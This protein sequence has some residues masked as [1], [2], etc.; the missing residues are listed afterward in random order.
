MRSARNAFAFALAFSICAPAWAQ[1]AL[2]GQPPAAAIK[3]PKAPALAAPPP[4]KAP[5]IAAAP[6]KLTAPV[7]VNTATEAQLD[8]IPQIGSKRAASI[9]KNRPYRSLDEL[10]SKKAL[11]DG[12]FQ[13]IKP[14][15][16]I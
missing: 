16:T 8:T 2:P 11:P 3:P 15:I 7:N 12:I 6:A 14:Y 1:T 10:V 5:A 13:K 9:I 4:T